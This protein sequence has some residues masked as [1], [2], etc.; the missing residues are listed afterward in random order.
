MTSYVRKAIVPLAAGAAL[1]VGAAAPASAQTTQIQDGLVNVAVG[2]VT[3]TDVAD[4]AVAA[5]V[6]A[7]ICG[8]E[9]GPVA[10]LAT[11]VD[12][13]GDTVTVCQ[14]NDQNAG[15]VRIVN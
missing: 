12:A 8:V 6:A 3:V 1:V 13:T 14:N 15:P 2:D 5:A 11:Q 7:N 4:V 10:I 9:V